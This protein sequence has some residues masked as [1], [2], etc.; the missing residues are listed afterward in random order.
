MRN[1]LTGYTDPV[2]R[3]RYIMW[4]GVGLILLV[5]LLFG[6]LAGTST[7]WF[8]NDVC[9][10]VHYDNEQQYYASTHSNI[11]CLACHI[12]VNL[13]GVRFTAEK[14]E[15]LPDVWEVLTDSFHIPLNEASYIALSMPENQCTQCHNLKTRD[16]TPS[17][18]IIIDHAVH[19]EADIA[20]SICHNRVAHNQTPELKLPGNE[21]YEEFMSMT[22]CFRCHTLTDSSPSEFTAP[23]TCSACHTPEFELKPPSH[24]EDGFYTEYGDSSGHAQLAAAEIEKVSA[25]EEYWAEVGP[26]LRDKGPK[27]ISALLRIPRGE[28]LDLPPVAAVDEC[29]TCHVKDTFCDGCHIL[30]MPHPADF[31]EQHSALGDAQPDTCALCHNKTGDPAL[32]ATS[33]DQCH[34]SAGD[35]LQTWLS[36]HDES[37]R[38]TDILADCYTCHEELFCSVCHV[39]G[40]KPSRY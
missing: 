12:P 21:Y 40:V 6:S 5:A 11:S 27:P 32:N 36:Q 34:H 7:R 3:P 39:R 28:F 35:P 13:D 16:P 30:E 38:A 9:H 14:A 10:M 33:C 22:A 31:V 18:G 23:G 1:P 25:A 24:F 4:T 19:S 29:S 15:K 26:K 17:E 37:A 2:R 8:C 20:C